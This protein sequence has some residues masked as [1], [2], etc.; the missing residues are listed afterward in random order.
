MSP[1]RAQLKINPDAVS[2]ASTVGFSVIPFVPLKQ[3]DPLSCPVVEVKIN[4]STE[5][6]SF[7][8]D[9]GT[10]SFSIS[11]S[12]AKRLD[13]TI[14]RKNLSKTKLGDNK[15]SLDI[16]IISSI[17]CGNLEWEVEALL[18]DDEAFG[19]FNKHGKKIVGIIGM[20]VLGSYSVYVDNYKKEIWL[21]QGGDFANIEMRRAFSMNFAQPIN[22]LEKNKAYS[23]PVKINGEGNFTMLIDNGASVTCVS[24]KSITSQK[25]S[26][27]TIGSIIEIGTMDSGAIKARYAKGYISL[28]AYPLIKIDPW[29]LLESDVVP[30]VDGMLG[31]DL[32]SKYDVLLDFPNKMMYIKPR[33]AP[34]TA[35]KPDG[36]P[37]VSPA[38]KGNKP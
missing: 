27:T 18:T 13:L 1:A 10:N 32:L 14:Q 29:I 19:Q 6:L 25:L 26:V 28:F 38:T 2:R 23:V 16:A 21:I 4:G 17:V 11:R 5:P 9:T 36:T 34:E 12:L 30:L 35:P 37:P 15:S 3:K 33:A 8:I 20:Q 22:L 24:K 31:N 7:L